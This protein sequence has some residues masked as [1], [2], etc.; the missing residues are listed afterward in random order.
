MTKSNLPKLYKVWGFFFS[1][2][3]ELVEG[4]SVSATELQRTKLQ[5]YRAMKTQT[6][7]IPVTLSSL[8]QKS[9]LYK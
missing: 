3:F 5:L 2:P 1:S 6:F 8:P 7:E 9:Y 4:I